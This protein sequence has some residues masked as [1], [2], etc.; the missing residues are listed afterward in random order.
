MASEVQLFIG[1]IRSFVALVLIDVSIATSPAEKA[2]RAQGEYVHPLRL[3]L[4]SA[5]PNTP[6]PI[7][8]A[9]I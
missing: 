5:D 9:G 7:N 1:D 8:L 3:H 2:T 4:M 6:F